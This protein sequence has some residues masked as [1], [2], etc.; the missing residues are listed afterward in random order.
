M[1][2]VATSAP[3]WE[4]RVTLESMEKFLEYN[5]GA[6]IHRISPTPL[7]MVVAGDDRLTP[8][9]LAIEAYERAREPK[10][11]VLFKGGHFDAY[12]VP[13]LN[14]TAGSAAEWFRQHLT[15]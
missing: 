13:G 5:P 2:V 8:T 4:N 3:R 10:K 14:I 12:Q 9:D 6:N 7:L 15:H 11:M 1:K